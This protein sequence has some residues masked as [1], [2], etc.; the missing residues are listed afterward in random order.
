MCNTNS[1][2]RGRRITMKIILNFLFMFVL[3]SSL[4]AGVTVTGQAGKQVQLEQNAD[5]DLVVVP[6]KAGSAGEVQTSLQQ[7]QQELTQ[8]M[9]GESKGEK[10]T[11]QNQNQVRLAV[12]A[13]LAME[14]LVGGVGKQVSQIAKE[15]DNSVQAT[16][17]AENRVNERSSF[18]RMF[19]GGDHEAA[20]EIEE[21]VE[22]NKA[23]IALLKQ[24]KSQCD[25][26]SDVKAMYQEQV[27]LMEQEQARLGELAKD[28]KDSKGMFGWLWK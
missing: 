8:E 18:S 19:F 6:E 10:K 1:K 14:D 20:E 17:N 16:I 24:L 21:Q 23:R 2:W 3:M 5:G 13:L 27:T 15:F 28:E 4:V 7:R 26:G 22:S 11:L 12:H 25:C 9:A